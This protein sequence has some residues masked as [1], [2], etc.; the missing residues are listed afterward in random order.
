MKIVKSKKKF[1][2]MNGYTEVASF[3]S[4]EDAQA[5]LSLKGLADEKPKYKKGARPCGV[6]RYH[7]GAHS[8]A[9][10]LEADYEYVAGKYTSNKRIVD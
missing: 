6:K 9:L 10:N 4:F 3:K 7:G 1:L 5:Y 2:I 8:V